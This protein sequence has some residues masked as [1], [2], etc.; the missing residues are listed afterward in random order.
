MWIVLS[1]RKAKHYI[2]I[3]SKYKREK[4]TAVL[5]GRADRIRACGVLV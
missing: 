4:E 3:V 5:K 1:L 2:T